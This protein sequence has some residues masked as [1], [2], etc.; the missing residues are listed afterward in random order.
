MIYVLFDNKLSII[1]LYLF[2]FLSIY[3]CFCLFFVEEQRWPKRVLVFLDLSILLGKVHK[4]E[5]SISNI[6][7]SETG[8]LD[9]GKPFVFSP[10]LGFGFGAQSDRKL[11]KCKVLYEEDG[12]S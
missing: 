12:I 6:K 4:I 10:F 9:M 2:D 5:A 1:R 7:Y 3:F 11:R 8:K